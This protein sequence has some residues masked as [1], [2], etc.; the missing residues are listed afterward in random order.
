MRAVTQYLKRRGFACVDDSWYS[1][2]RLWQSWYQGKVPAFH[3]Y[4]QYNGRRKV[5]RTRKSLGMAKTIPE[6]CW[7]W[8][9]PWE[10]G[11][12]WSTWRGTGCA[13]TTSGRG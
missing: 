4:R 12:S 5:A 3:C 6:D 2:I 9:S 7:S 10:R 8:P 1:L 13:S 11:P